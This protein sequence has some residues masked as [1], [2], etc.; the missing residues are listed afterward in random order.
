MKIGQRKISGD[1][2]L[3]LVI[4][5]AVA[6]RVIY[7]LSFQKSAL[8]GFVDLDHRYYLEWAQRIADGEWLGSEVFE[9]A[10]LYPYLVGSFFRVFGEQLDWLIAIQ[11][12]AGVLT[13][14]LIYLSG[15][16]LFSR[17]VAIGGGLLVAV[18]GPLVFYEGLVMKSFLSP[19]LTTLTLYAG[20]RFREHFKTPWLIVAGLAIGLACVVRE[21]H[22]LLSLPIAWEVWLHRRESQRFIRHGLILCASIA[23]CLIPS[24]VRNWSV[25]GEFVVVTAGGGEVFYM[26][27]GPDAE[28]FYHAPDFV[29]PNPFTEHEDFRR[30]A[31]RRTRREL[32]RGESS[33]YWFRQGLSYAVQHPF[34]EVALSIQKLNVLLHDFEVNDSGN[35]RVAAR[36]IPV[37]RWLPTFGWIS[38]LGLLGMVVSL[39]DCRRYG[40]PLLIVA[41]HVLSVI[42]T[43]NFGRFRLGLVPIW[44]L[45]SVSG[46]AWLYHFWRTKSSRN[47]MTATMVTLVVLLATLLF[48]QIPLG[49]SRLTY[50]VDDELLLAKLALREKDIDA[51]EQYF[52]QALEEMKDYQADNRSRV[53]GDQVALLA[54]KVGDQLLNLEHVD[55]AVRFY[56]VAKDQ[57]N[58]RS[59]RHA[60]L[61][62]LMRTLLASSR[63][64]HP[65]ES[66]VAIDRL[67]AEVLA[68]LRKVEPTQ[69]AYWALSAHWPNHESELDQI[70]ERLEKLWA[71]SNQ[72]SPGIRATYLMGQAFLFEKSGE[73]ELARRAARVALDEVSDH[74]A[75]VELLE[76]LN[77]TD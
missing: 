29:K 77:Q 11:H 76:I 72:Q 66:S 40:L 46:V 26:A 52:L 6:V 16:R 14:V 42:L 45:F 32:T 71:R 34:R 7:F 27:H 60:L 70:R 58:D 68:E 18:F 50:A 48:F 61:Q 75:K 56:E 55:Q 38:A 47:R 63:K 25:A 1:Q 20:L 51:A 43:Y 57:P 73:T 49:S 37:L 21:N 59:H 35:Y 10:P 24:A 8:A 41:A 30:E 44:C 12:V 5:V 67:L 62:Q 74:P 13:A 3:W 64:G 36:L 4:A 9:Q 33:R 54:L 23:V 69:I 31:E 22:I 15:C 65:L 19:L 2:G 17:P 28:P 39:R 53:D